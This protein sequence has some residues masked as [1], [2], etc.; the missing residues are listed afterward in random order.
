M[1]EAAAFLET[2]LMYLP[3]CTALLS[4]RPKLYLNDVRMCS[5]LPLLSFASL[6]LI[7]GVCQFVLSLPCKVALSFSFFTFYFFPSFA[8]DISACFL[9]LP[10]FFVYHPFNIFFKFSYLLS[11]FYMCPDSSVDIPTRYGLDGPGVKSR[12]GERHFPNTPRPIPR[13]IQLSFE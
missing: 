3:S 10:F 1:K 8:E 13:P 7:F 12:C 4:A 11:F 6:F 9:F 5:F 2:V